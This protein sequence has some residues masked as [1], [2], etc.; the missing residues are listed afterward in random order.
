MTIYR[1][2]DP[3]DPR[4]HPPQDPPPPLAVP[5]PAP[6]NRWTIPGVALLAT[7]VGFGL[8][9]VANSAG[10]ADQSTG[11][12]S[13]FAA[14]YSSEFAAG[15]TADPA[16]TQDGTYLV[17]TDIQPGSYRSEAGADCYWQLGDTSGK[18]I[19]NGFE[20]RPIITIPAEAYTFTSTGCGT[21]EKVG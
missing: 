9:S 16:L 3:T 21:W 4:N 8:G 20:A 19:K 5:V 15:P 6:R 17:G 12:S 18:I 11:L 7:V 10:T 1:S 2:D 13:T 14:D